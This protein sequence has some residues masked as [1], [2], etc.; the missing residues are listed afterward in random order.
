MSQE[1]ITGKVALVQCEPGLPLS[2]FTVWLI[3][4]DPKNCWQISCYEVKLNGHGVDLLTCV[5]A[6]VQ[7]PTTEKLV[8]DRREWL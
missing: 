3:D 7:A 5:T 2:Y 8:V 1:T 6:I 4:G